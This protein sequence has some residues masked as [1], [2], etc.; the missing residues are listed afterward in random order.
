MSA[1]GKD[2][3]SKFLS[4]EAGDLSS[5][6]HTVDN[7]EM[8]F[9]DDADVAKKIGMTRK[10]DGKT[11]VR[12]WRR[13]EGVQQESD[14]EEEEEQEQEQEQE[15]AK[16]PNSGPTAASAPEP[17]RQP[18]R[19]RAA[20]S[21][22]SSSDDDA[23]PRTARKRISAAVVTTKAAAP[24]AAAPPAA[25]P[26]AARKIVG[27]SS[28]SEESDSDSEAETNRRAAIKAKIMARQK[29]QEEERTIREVSTKDTKN[30]KD[31]NEAGGITKP[32]EKENEEEE[33]E[34]GDSG[35][36][37]DSD[38]DSSSEEE[39]EE[40]APPPLLKFIP[41]S[42]RGTVV[43]Q[44]DLDNKWESD[45]KKKT[46]AKKLRAIETQLA[47]AEEVQREKDTIASDVTND[48]EDLAFM[49]DDA[50]DPTDEAAYQAWE[51]RE[52]TRLVEELMLNDTKTQKKL[53]AEVERR[54]RMTDEERMAEDSSLQEKIDREK[55]EKRAARGADNKDGK[56]LMMKYQHKGAFYMD[57]DTLKADPNDVRNKNYHKEAT[58]DS[59]N[60]ASMPK[61]MQ[62]RN[63]GRSGQSKHTTNREIDTTDSS[64]PASLGMQALKRKR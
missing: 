27:D 1:F 18:A 7:T 25:A 9:K 63:F 57:E 37:S 12:R 61:V 47:V 14:S 49:P 59:F 39:E 31:T 16:K 29:Q 24:P 35:S 33:E 48:Q 11:Q 58:S 41:K 42:K 40:E 4:T 23:A 54:R 51:E 50:D 26:P 32:E 17:A 44:A 30:T 19:R 22:S 38:S 34:E 52:I 13:G 53:K 20:S 60:V 43:T 64:A 3:L 55:E 8:T 45:E 36:S 6:R 56:K 28:S 15:V 2:D 5:L 21:D 62:V 46:E 10:A